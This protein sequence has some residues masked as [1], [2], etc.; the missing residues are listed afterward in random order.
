MR[1]GIYAI[2]H[3]ESGRWYV[4]Q[5]RDLDRRWRKHSSQLRHNH[6]NNSHLQNTWNKYG[7]EAFDFEVLILAPV[8]LL[9]DLEQAYLDDP[10]T[11]H[12]NVARHADAPARGLIRSAETKALISQ[13]SAEQRRLP[14]S[15]ETRAKLSASRRGYRCSP[16]TR[17]KMSAAKKG[18]K[19]PPRTPEHRAKLSAANRGRQRSPETRAKM[20]AA[21]LGRPRSPE[22]RAKQSSS[23][24]ATLAA[25]RA[26]KGVG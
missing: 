16:E 4:G 21:H 19:Q 22:S 26:Q 17:A 23:L 11:S 8:R 12:F 6:H 18:R 10:E 20:R 15:A 2:I 13:A 5:S 24:K 7:P 25:K 9:N 3:R 14:C 1:S